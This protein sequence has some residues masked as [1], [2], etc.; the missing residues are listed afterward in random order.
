MAQCCDSSNADSRGGA[1]SAT[2]ALAASKARRQALVRVCANRIVTWD[3]NTEHGT[4]A[5][6]SVLQTL[7]S[8][9]KS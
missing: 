5:C 3:H 8:H 6:D 1:A 7:C 2:A 4:N 9:R